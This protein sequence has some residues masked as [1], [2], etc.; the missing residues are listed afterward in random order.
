M[1]QTDSFE[2]KPLG[3]PGYEHLGKQERVLLARWIAKFPHLKQGAL[4]D[5]SLIPKKEQG[6]SHVTDIEY[7]RNWNYLNCPRLDL[8]TVAMDGSLV[9]YEIRPEADFKAIC[10]IIGYRELI[11]IYEELKAPV[12]CAIITDGIAKH[13]QA[14]ADK[15][16]VTVFIV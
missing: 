4:C 2:H 11:K 8:L 6:E 16:S 12:R 13:N 10:D 5:Y 14:I 9:I 15:L 1:T 7:K 3:I